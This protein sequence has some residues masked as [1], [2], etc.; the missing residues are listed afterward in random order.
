MDRR[1]DLRFECFDG[2][3]GSNRRGFIEEQGEGGRDAKLARKCDGFVL[4]VGWDFRS[5]KVTQIFRLDP[6]H[7]ICSGTHIKGSAF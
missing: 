5:N 6:D 4:T 1:K 3:T 7:P 2:E